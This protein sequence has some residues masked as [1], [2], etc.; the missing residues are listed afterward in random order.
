MSNELPKCKLCESE[1]E[2]ERQWAYCPNMGCVL[3][4]VRMSLDDWRRLHGPSGD[5]DAWKETARQAECNVA[6]YRDLLD[7]IAA[8]LGSDAYLAD[9]GTRFQNP[10]R[11]KLPEL[12]KT[13]A[14]RAAALEQ[15][16]GPRL[17]PEH[18]EALRCLADVVANSRGV[19][20]WHRNGDMAEWN[21]FGDFCV[22]IRAAL[23]ALGEG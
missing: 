11:A 3:C 16:H 9:D 19:T 13:L 4:G 14:Q 17:A 7:Q 15:E 18:V 20:G 22:A 2:T 1:P 10:L 6:Y 8:W 23:A 12:V 21:E 5:A